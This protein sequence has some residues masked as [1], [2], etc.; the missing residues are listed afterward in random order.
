MIADVCVVRWS[1]RCFKPHT[2]RELPYVVT[3]AHVM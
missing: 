1:F 2:E 3:K